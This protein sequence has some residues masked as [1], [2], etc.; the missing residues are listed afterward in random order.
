MRFAM[1]GQASPARTTYTSPLDAAPAPPAGAAGA[2]GAV[3]VVDVMGMVR[4]EV[5]A[6]MLVVP[7][8]RPRPGLLPQAAMPMPNVAASTMSATARLR[9]RSSIGPQAI[10]RAEPAAGHWPATLGR[11]GWWSVTAS[12]SP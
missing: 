2:G 3:L 5:L 11:F 6:G 9:T 7:P 10:A 4:N 12:S 8:D 1:S